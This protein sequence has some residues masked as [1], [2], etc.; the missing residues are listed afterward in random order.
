MEQCAKESGRCAARYADC[1]L[2]YQYKW[3]TDLMILRTETYTSTQWKAVAAQSR[4][5]DCA[6]AYE[7]KWQADL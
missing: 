2:A 5:V 6:L 1:A 7:C 4:Y 3:Q